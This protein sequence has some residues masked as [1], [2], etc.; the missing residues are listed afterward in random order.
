MSSLQSGA[1][2]LYIS[3]PFCRS[4]CTYCNFASGVY[5]ASEHARYVERLIEDLGASGAWA[6]R[7]NL[8]LPRRVDTVYLGGGT[9]SLLAPELLA[10]LFAA[11]RAAFDF[12]QDAEIT[13]ECA[14]GQIAD[15]TLK[16]L[17]AAGVNRVSLGVQSFI[18]RE[19]AA[20]GRLHNR[21]MVEEDLRRLRGVGIAN[22][23]VDLIAGLAGQT[24]ASWDESV[25]AL[26]DSGVPHASVYMLEVD[27]DSRLG[28]ELLARGVRYHAN[29]VPSDDAIAQMYAVAI[30]KLG[31]AGLGQHEISN[32]GRPGFASRHN[33]RYWQRR[34]YLGLGLDASSMLREALPTADS[35][36][37]G[38]VLRTTTTDDLAAYLAGP[39]PA[40]TAW[41]SAE[42][43]HEEAWFLGLR[44]NAGVEVAALERE[45]GRAVVAQT[46]ETVRRLV[47]DGLVSSDGKTVRLTA[48]GQLLSNDVFQEFLGLEE[49][50]SQGTRA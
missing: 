22:L 44:L 15:D 11:M 32:F 36:G 46:M 6:A 19:A 48:R 5:P 35:D 26:I 16:A 29:V 45:F 25:A 39:E 43:Q 28:R 12:E 17:A 42:R 1:L 40:E 33:L 20:S 2:G 4:K 50:V 31:A 10:R 27:E 14:P 30:E 8:D 41:L 49:K 23:N 37:P 13:V 18:D 9:P 34:P 3:I 24:F 38:Y 7:M 47:E 21:A